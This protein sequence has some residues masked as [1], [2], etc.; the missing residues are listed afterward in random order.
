MFRLN[1]APPFSPVDPVTDILHG[2]PVTD[3]YR[4]LEHR[5]SSRTRAWIEEQTSYARAQLDSIPGRD[6]IR[7]RIREFLAVESH[8]SLQKAGDRYFFRKRLPCQEQPCIYMRN[9]ADGED[10][11][12]IDPLERGTGKYTAVKLLRVSP[13]GR[14]LLYEIKEGGQRTGTFELLEIETRKRLPD[15]LPRGYLRGFAFAPDGKSFYY[16]HEAVG[17]KRPFYRAAYH[18]VLGLSPSGD[19]EIFLAGEDEKIRLGLFSDRKRLVL[20]VY[21]FFE[22]TLRD[23]YLRPFDRNETFQNRFS[24]KSI[25]PLACGC[26]MTGFSPLRTAMRRIAASSKSG[27]ATTDNMNGS[28]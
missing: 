10:Q 27:F 7:D 22:K 20:I 3:P 14:F 4:W 26:S 16:V 5:N 18:H 2:V 24:A 17:A 25:I 6:R 21:R 1:A 19:Q 23:I 11:L 8:D 28:M 12:L 9:G 13:D 15:F